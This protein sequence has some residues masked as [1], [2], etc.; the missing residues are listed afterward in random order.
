M[1][2]GITIWSVSNLDVCIVDSKLEIR[3]KQLADT[4]ASSGSGTNVSLL[5]LLVGCLCRLIHRPLKCRP[6]TT[7]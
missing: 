5:L 1:N 2:P 4:Q 7:L 3:N 6:C